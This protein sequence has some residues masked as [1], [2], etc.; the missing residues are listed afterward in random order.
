MYRRL[1]LLT[2]VFGSLLSACGQGGNI[3]EPLSPETLV[4]IRLPMG[5]IP[6]IQYAPIYVAEEKGYFTEAGFE[7]EFDYGFETDGVA[8][9]GAGELPFAVVSGEQVLLARAQKVPVVYVMAWFQDFPV[10]VA[11]K[12]GSGIE[13]PADLYG[14]KIGLPGLFGASYIGL[15]ALLNAGGI[16][17]EDVVLDSIGYNQVEALAMDQEEAVVVYVTNEPVQ[18]RAQGY[19]LNLIRVADYVQLAANGII[20]NETTIAEDP[21]VIR[22]FIG[23]VLRGL[24]YTIENPEEAYAISMNFVEG[25]EEGDAIQ[26]EVLTLSIDFWRADTLGHSDRSAWE[27]MQEVLLDMGLLVEPLDLDEAFTN[28]YI[29]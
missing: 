16:R 15:R 3:D 18:L 7:I 6:N 24:E 11:A 5:Y 12:A 2:L 29:D 9:V 10:A 27:N 4:Q 13:T 20:T 26:M 23:A 17:E 1:L 28:D 21:N 19:Q 22:R 8:L 14:K 25:L